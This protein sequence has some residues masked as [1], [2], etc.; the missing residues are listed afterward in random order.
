MWEG[1]CR[2]NG[3]LTVTAE[4]QPII[5]VPP[6]QALAH[7][8]AKA[9]RLEPGKPADFETRLSD[10]VQLRE[11]GEYQLVGTLHRVFCPNRR[12]K[13]RAA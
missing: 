8:F 11:S 1:C 13:C 12:P 3:R 2:L 4:N 5:P 9:E 10:W 6:V 7:M